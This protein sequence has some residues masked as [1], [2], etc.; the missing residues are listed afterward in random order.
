MDIEDLFSEP[1]QPMIIPDFG[2]PCSAPEGAPDEEEEKKEGCGCAS[3]SSKDC[4]K[5]TETKEEESKES[6]SK[7]ALCFKCKVQPAVLKNK[8]DKVCKA[9]FLELLTHKF[10]SSLRIN[11]KIWKDDLNLVCVSGGVNSMAVLDLI[12]RSLLGGSSNRKM[13][14]KVHV[15]YIEEASVV[16]G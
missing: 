14:F 4:C 9:C 1:E 12:F 3:K 6:S 5:S 8:Q 2:P 10:K 13:F 16:F 11:L 7:K 15:L